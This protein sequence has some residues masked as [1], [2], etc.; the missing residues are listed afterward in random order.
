MAVEVWVDVLGFVK[1]IQL[2]RRIC[3]VNWKIYEIC[4]PRLHGNRVVEHRV[5]DIVIGYE[6]ESAAAGHSP[7]AV[8][9]K[10]NKKVPFPECPLPSYI[11]GFN[12]IQIK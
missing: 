4:W 7:T 5:R 12:R 10:D 8:L 2:A 3:L 9:M 11:T 6:D 1:R